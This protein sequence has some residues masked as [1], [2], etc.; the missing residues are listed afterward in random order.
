M[1]LTNP[2]K[3]ILCML[4]EIYEKLEIKS[5]T[6]IE[7]I[8]KTIDKNHTWALSWERPGIVGDP[9]DS[10]PPEVN[11]VND[12]LEMWD[13]IELV[14]V[15]LNDSEKKQIQDETNSFRNDVGFRGFDGNNESKHMSIAKFFV[16]DMNCF[17]SFKDR[18]FNSHQRMLPI[19]TKM[20]FKLEEIREQYPYQQLGVPEIIEI[21]NAPNVSVTQPNE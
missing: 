3:L 16:E 11:L 6:D 15:S 12:I 18:N 14:Y 4:A 17:S 1:K 5:E 20:V 10:T 19:Y 21:L 9:P 7:F 2:E 8:R 13:S